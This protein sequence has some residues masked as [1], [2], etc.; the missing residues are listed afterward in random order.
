MERLGQSQHAGS[1][2]NWKEERFVEA[3]QLEKIKR[4]PILKNGDGRGRDP[5]KLTQH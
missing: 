2:G 3:L 5:Q 4:L 1:E